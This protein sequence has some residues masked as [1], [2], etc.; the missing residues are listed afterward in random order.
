[1]KRRAMPR[2][3][4]NEM[5][6]TCPCA[7]R[8]RSARLKTQNHPHLNIRQLQRYRSFAPSARSLKKLNRIACAVG[9]VNKLFRPNMKYLL[10]SFWIN[11]LK[12]TFCFENHSKTMF[13]AESL[14][15]CIGE[16][17]GKVPKSRERCKVSCCSAYIVARERPR[18]FYRCYNL[19]Q[20]TEVGKS[21]EAWKKI[22]NS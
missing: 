4:K 2:T 20:Y 18:N 6:L 5:I 3:V 21:L 19:K 9:N 10:I 12:R 11:K 8:L 14:L 1:M 15:D 16:M 17:P 7:N 13:C 22:K